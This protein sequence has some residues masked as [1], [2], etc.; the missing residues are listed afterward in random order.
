MS[1]TSHLALL[2]VCAL[3]LTTHT[4]L[5]QPTITISFYKNDGYGVGNDIGGTWTVN[6]QT[7][8]DVVSVEFYLDGTLEMNDTSTP[9]AWQFKTPDYPTGPHI[10]TATAFDDTG[11]SASAQVLKSFQSQSTDSVMLMTLS[12]AGVAVIL[13]VA[14]ALYFKKKR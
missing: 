4:A 12:A 9:F 8:A 6:A 2:I 14:V 7:S 3:I 10:I 1:S 13:V 11:G 5:A